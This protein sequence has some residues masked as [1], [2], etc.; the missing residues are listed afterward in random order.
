MLLHVELDTIAK[1]GEWQWDSQHQVASP[2]VTSSTD[3]RQTSVSLTSESLVWPYWAWSLLRWSTAKV[4]WAQFRQCG[5]GVTNSVIFL[6]LL[7]AVFQ[8]KASSSLTASKNLTPRF[9]VWTKCWNLSLNYEAS[10]GWTIDARSS[11]IKQAAHKAA[12]WPC[13]A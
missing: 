8:I 11:P 3:C 1:G 12:E 2:M 10:F 13:S 5:N 7:P 9:C 6:A 4:W